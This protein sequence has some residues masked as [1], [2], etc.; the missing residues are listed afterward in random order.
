MCVI[1]AEISNW[2]DFQLVA[3]WGF[4]VLQRIVMASGAKKDCVDLI[5]LKVQINVS[6][7]VMYF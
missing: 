6:Q 7:I 2:T 4:S 3:P 1:Y 5:V